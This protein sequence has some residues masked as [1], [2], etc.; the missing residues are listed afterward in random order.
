MP[1][2]EAPVSPGAPIAGVSVEAPGRRD[3]PEPGSTE[4]AALIALVF[5]KAHGAGSLDREP[6]SRRNLAIMS[7]FIVMAAVVGLMLGASYLRHVLSTTTST[8]AGQHPARSQSEQNLLMAASSAKS[9]E[10][11]HSLTVAGLTSDLA[12]ADP[13]LSFPLVSGSASEVSIALPAPGLVVLTDYQPS[14]AACVGIL[15]VISNQSAP[16]FPVDGATTQRGTYYF[17]AQPF[18]GLCNALGVT[19]PGPSYISASGFPTASLP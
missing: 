1:S 19:P 15:Q 10:A 12:A 11:S 7:I 18:S 5:G 16:I 4:E 13:S 14:T 8:P 2:G 3:A 17:E 6:R 9:Y